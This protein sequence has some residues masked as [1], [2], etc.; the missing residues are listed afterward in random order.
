[1]N[2]IIIILFILLP[3]IFLLNKKN[4]NNIKGKYPVPSEIIQKKKDRELFKKGNVNWI[5]EY[6]RYT[7]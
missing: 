1:M 6:K 4:K 3:I 2:K 7:S 5:H